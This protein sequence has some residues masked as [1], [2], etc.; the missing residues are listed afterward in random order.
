MMLNFWNVSDYRDLLKSYYE[1]RKEELSI[2]SYRM[3]GEKLGVDSSYLYRV[4]Q[5]RQQ[6]PSRSIPAARELLGLTG[7]AAEYFDL[8]VAAAKSKNSKENHELMEKA[9]ALR[10]VAR[11]EITQ[12]ELRFFG[13]WWIPAVRAYL[14]ISGGDANPKRIAEYIRPKI[15]EAQATE[16]LQLLKDLG[17]VKR[18]ASGKLKIADAHL[19][20]GGPE[21]IQAVRRYQQ[22]ILQLAAKAIDECP[23]DKR[24]ISTLTMAVDAAAFDDIRDMLREM[25]RLIQKRVDE[26]V[27]PDRIME[28]SMAFFPVT[29]IRK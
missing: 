22:E 15:T 7:R 16:A 9:L 26:S 19:T 2:Y 24:D 10:D 18:L 23:V 6:L 17:L 12:S 14:E 5:K 25:R 21:K 27:A 28:L 8:L 20:V 4:L 29:E 11:K 13:E 1:R 3:M